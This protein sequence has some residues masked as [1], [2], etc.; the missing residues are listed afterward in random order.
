MRP[1]LALLLASTV[2]LT[3]C[4]SMPSWLGGGEPTKSDITGERVAVLLANKKYTADPALQNEVITVPDAADSSWPQTIGTAAGS[5]GNAALPD[6]IS[7]RERTEVGSG[8]SFIK[9]FSAAPV[10][11]NGRVYAMDAAGNISAHDAKD[12][13]KRL[14]KSELDPDNDDEAQLGGGLSVEGNRLYAV[15]GNGTV[16][17]LDASSGKLLWR[18]NVAA[19]TRSAPRVFEGKVYVVAADSQLFALDAANGASLW[20]HRGIN[21]GAGF[22][23]AVSPNVA[24]GVV[25]VPYASGELYGLQSDSGQVTWNDGLTMAQRTTA[26]GIFSGIGGDPVVTDG[27]VYASGAAGFTAA[28]RAETGQRLWER[29]ASSLNTLW[30]AGSAVFML[31]DDDT[32]LALNRIDGRIIWATPLPRYE[33]EEK[34]TD[35]LHWSGPVLAG[36]KLYVAGAHGELKSF[37]PQTGKALETIDIEEGVYSAPVVAGGVMYLATSDAELVALH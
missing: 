26:I 10:V 31:T 34:H 13:G 28:F 3:A 33:D 14:W 5:I 8:E 37:M 30:P 7:T 9:G 4:D 16:A 1:T 32:L 19:P 25:I 35:R 12:I 15:L 6:K 11:A 36:N 27:I 17:A 24:G 23:A 29:A 22:L 18:V 21:E 20:S 2:L